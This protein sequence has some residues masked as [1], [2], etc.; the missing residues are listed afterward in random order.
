MRPQAT[1]LPRL[2]PER[3]EREFLPGVTLFE[4]GYA[5]AERLCLGVRRW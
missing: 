3:Y 1:A 2:K 4:E 5:T